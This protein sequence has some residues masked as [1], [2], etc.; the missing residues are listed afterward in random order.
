MLAGELKL[1]CLFAQQRE[2]APDLLNGF[3]ELVPVDLVHVFNSPA[4]ASEA[5]V[6]HLFID[7]AQEA[8]ASQ[9][10]LGSR[11]ALHDLFVLLQ[12]IEEYLQVCD[13]VVSVHDRA[14]GGLAD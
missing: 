1:V 14:V 6:L 8:L 13:P 2:Q 11:I 9:R 12:L 7:A 5:L 10:L 3:H 4:R